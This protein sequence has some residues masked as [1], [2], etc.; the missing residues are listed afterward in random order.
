MKR[1]HARILKQL[2]ICSAT[3]VS[4][5]M[6]VVLIDRHHKDFNFYG[7]LMKLRF[8]KIRNMYLGR[9]YQI[10]RRGWDALSNGVKQ[11]IIAEYEECSES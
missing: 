1:D 5:G 6:G 2:A 9:T 8:I 10:T 11:E 3:H 4:K 7:E